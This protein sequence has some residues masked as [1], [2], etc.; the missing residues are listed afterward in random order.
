MFAM[1]AFGLDVARKLPWFFK[2][3][4][5]HDTRW[6]LTKYHGKPNRAGGLYEKCNTHIQ[7]V[8]CSS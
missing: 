3:L 4:F 2:K 7:G 1:V 5:F 8:L 6:V